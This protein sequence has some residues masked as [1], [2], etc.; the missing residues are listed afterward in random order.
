MIE[1]LNVQGRLD[2]RGGLHCFQSPNKTWTPPFSAFDSLTIV[3][4]KLE[5]IKLWP[6][7][8][9]GVKNSKK[10]NHQTLP[11]FIPKHS[12]NSLYIALL[13]PIRVQRW[14]VEL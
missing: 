2:L 4:N 14:F 6:P 11:Q 7:K 10:T 5:M 13:Q 3:E 8:V 12:K 9:K 1:H